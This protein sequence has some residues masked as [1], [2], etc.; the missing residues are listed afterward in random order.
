MTSDEWVEARGGTDSRRDIRTVE[1]HQE[2]PS[3]FE[4]RS[5]S[6][7]RVGVVGCGYWGAKHVRVLAAAA[8]S[9]RLSSS[10]PTRSVE[11]DCTVP[12]RQPP[13]QSRCPKGSHGRCRGDRHTGTDPCGAHARRPRRGQ[14]RAR[15]EADGHVGERCR[16]SHPARRGAGSD[17]HGRAHVRTKRRCRRWSSIVRSGEL[18]QLKYLTSTR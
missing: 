15:R 7:M 18:G 8:R 2:P 4:R 10:N 1:A 16:E 17:P 3:P 9:N 14:A 13:R 5:N 11:S 6:N 12:T